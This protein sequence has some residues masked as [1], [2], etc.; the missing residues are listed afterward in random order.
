[1]LPGIYLLWPGAGIP[2][3]IWLN[4]RGRVDWCQPTEFISFNQLFAAV[5]HRLHLARLEPV[6][7]ASG[8]PRRSDYIRLYVEVTRLRT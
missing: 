1:M 5:R 4:W 7:I 8:W 2:G 6:A 3:G